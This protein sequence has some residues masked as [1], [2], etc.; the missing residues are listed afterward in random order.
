[1]KPVFEK[2]ET[3]EIP[4]TGDSIEAESA[5]QTSHDAIDRVV[6]RAEELQRN[7]SKTNGAGARSSSRV[8]AAATR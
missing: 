7:W 1:M 4:P 6:R 8:S 5:S 2:L 3:L